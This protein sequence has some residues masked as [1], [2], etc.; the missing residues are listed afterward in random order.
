MRFYRLF[1]IRAGLDVE[2]EYSYRWGFSWTG[3]DPDEAEILSVTDLDNVSVETT[4][5]EDEMILEA[6]FSDPPDPDY[7]DA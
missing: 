3:T 2:V 4:P 1:L 5:Q 6:I 7:D